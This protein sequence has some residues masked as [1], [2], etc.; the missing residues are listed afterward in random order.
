MLDVRA[1]PPLSDEQFDLHNK[2][3]RKLTNRGIKGMMVVIVEFNMKNNRGE[4]WGWLQKKMD[5]YNSL[6]DIQDKFVLGAVDQKE[7]EFDE[8]E[9][10]ERNAKLI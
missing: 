2:V 10:F 4:D 7:L 5:Y 9:K 3:Y 1:I 6:R 8:D